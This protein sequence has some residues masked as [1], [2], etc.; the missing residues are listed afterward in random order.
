M[1][2]SPSMI[3]KLVRDGLPSNF[4]GSFKGPIKQTD[5]LPKSQLIRWLIFP[6]DSEIDYVNTFAMSAGANA[7]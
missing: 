2:T 5:L 6:I 3:K 7:K 4:A 1:E